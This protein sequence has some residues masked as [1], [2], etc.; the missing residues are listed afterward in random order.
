MLGIG[1]VNVVAYTMEIRLNVEKNLK[2]I[3]GDF[4][5]LES[6]ATS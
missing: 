3:I 1:L 6:K 4:G 2:L 5:P